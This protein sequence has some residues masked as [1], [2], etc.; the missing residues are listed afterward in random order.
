MKKVTGHLATDKGKYYAV[1]NLYDTEGKRKVKWHNLDL[2]DVKGNKR[3][4]QERLIEVLAKYNAGDLYLAENMTPAERE[5]NRIAN[6]LVSDYLLD[7]VEAHKNNIEDHTYEQYKSYLNLRIVPYF[8]KLKIKMNEL[9]G[10]EIQELYHSMLA[11]GLSGTTVQ[12]YHGVLHKA[13]KDAVK[14]R[15]IVAN[16]A[17]QVTRP[18]KEQFIASF[19]NGNE[20]RHLLEVAKNDEIYIPITLTVYYGLRRSEVLGLKWSAIDFDEGTIT[21]KHTVHSGKDGPIGKDRLKTKSSYRTLP[22]HENIRE[23]LLE[24]RNKQE[25]MRKVMRSAYSKE[26]TDYICVDALGRLYDPNY[27]TSH[28]ATLLKQNN[29]RKIRFHDLR[30]SC[31]SLL[32]AQGVS[33]KLIQEWLGHS[34]MG[35]TANIYSHVDSV[36][37]LYTGNVISE[38]LGKD[39]E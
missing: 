31:A 20:M 39:K 37:K 10:D 7:W 32:V 3:K 22:L 26:Y 2:P 27:V 15:I 12:R 34:D 6:G 24:E 14:R 29:M 25:R 11:D 23:I 17:D 38:V 16:P 36:S 8:D 4:A 33:M 9:S 13:L 18:K 1:L 28:F 35:T 30:H 19:Y 21:I 5:R